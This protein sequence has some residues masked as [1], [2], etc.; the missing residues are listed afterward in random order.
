MHV[1]PNEMVEQTIPKLAAMGYEGL[2]FWEQYLS[3]ANMRRLRKAL[4]DNDIRAAQL[5][6]Y[7]DF[8]SGEKLWRW[9][10]KMAELYIQ[11]CLQ[12]ESSLIRTYANCPWDDRLPFEREGLSLLESA[13]TTDTQWRAIVKGL[14][15]ICEIGAKHDISFALETTYGLLDS[16]E[17]ILEVI[18][19]VEA[20]NLGVNLSLY[21]TW[22]DLK[23]GLSAMD[24][25]EKLGEH[26]IHVHANNWVNSEYCF[27]D[28]GQIDYERLTRR[29]YVSGFRD[30][31]SVEHATHGGRHDALRAAER[32]IAYVKGII[33]LIRGRR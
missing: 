24:T 10:V 25:V 1:I 19:K 4:R 20:D 13:N 27:L 31:I 15:K 17:S 8:A 9:S 32:E 29:L 11:R 5:C 3:G 14:R 22:G 18:D 30:F 16:S 6:P 21:P 23:E 28:E 7:F 12:L 33:K 26:I 2:E